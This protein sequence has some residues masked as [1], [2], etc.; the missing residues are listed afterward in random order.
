MKMHSPVTPMDHEPQ[1]HPDTR[2]L[3]LPSALYGLVITRAVVPRGEL[4]RADK[5]RGRVGQRTAEQTQQ[6]A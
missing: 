3:L 2:A 5:G 4:L 1:G 6:K